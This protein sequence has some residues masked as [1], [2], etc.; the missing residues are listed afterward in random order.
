MNFDNLFDVNIKK[1]KTITVE[2]KQ[3]FEEDCQIDL[4]KNIYIE[5]Y[6]YYEKKFSLKSISELKTEIENIFQNSQLT[7]AKILHYSINSTKKDNIDNLM[8]TIESSKNNALNKVKNI[9]GGFQISPVHIASIKDIF[10]DLILEKNNIQIINQKVMEELCY[11]ICLEEYI[12]K[13]DIK[14]DINEMNFISGTKISLFRDK[15]NIRSIKDI[16]K[17]IINN[18]TQYVQVL[19][20]DLFNEL[21]LYFFSG[22]DFNMNFNDELKI[23]IEKINTVK[24]MIKDKIREFYSLDNVKKL[25]NIYTKSK[26]NKKL[27]VSIEIEKIKEDITILKISMVQLKDNL[28]SCIIS[29]ESIPKDKKSENEIRDID[30]IKSDCIQTIENIDDLIKEA[31]KKISLVF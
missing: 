26:K 29:L 6:D 2:E 17:S 14:I 23:K 15:A 8:N 7:S 30:N 4:E 28:K 18:L 13:N 12:I 3:N 31:E 25:N 10:S 24:R 11:V 21:M 16:N 1:S 20:P 27:N 19:S 5:N 22:I 9:F